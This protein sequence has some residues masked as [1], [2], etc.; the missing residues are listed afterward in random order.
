VLIRAIFRALGRWVLRLFIGWATQALLRTGKRL[1]QRWRLRR[2][3]R[4]S[5]QE[6]S[7]QRPKR[8]LLSCFFRRKKPAPAPVTPEIPKARIGYFKRFRQGLVDT[9]INQTKKRARRFV[10]APIARTLQ[11]AFDF[12]GLTLTVRHRSV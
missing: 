8:R 5:F 1:W 7:V 10:E 4:P 6:P 2:T 3:G 12:V 9:A 11:G